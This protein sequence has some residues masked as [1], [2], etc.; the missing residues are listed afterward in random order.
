M[1]TLTHLQSQR[2]SR[3]KDW[4]SNQRTLQQLNQHRLSDEEEHFWLLW[5]AAFINHPWKKHHSTTSWVENPRICGIR[6]RPVQR[7]EN[8][9]RKTEGGHFSNQ[10][11]QLWSTLVSRGLK[12]QMNSRHLQEVVCLF[13]AHSYC[14]LPCR[15]DFPLQYWQVHMHYLTLDPQACLFSQ[16]S[17]QNKSTSKLPQSPICYNHATDGQNMWMRFQIKLQ[18]LWRK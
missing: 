5:A 10:S 14:R 16:M 9:W 2:K 18:P 12:F 8:K 13:C 7:G 6:W 4:A 1:H 11:N 3:N 15:K 17:F